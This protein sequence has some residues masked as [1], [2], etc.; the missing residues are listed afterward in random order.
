VNCAKIAEKVSG[1]GLQFSFCVK[2]AECAVI[3]ERIEKRVCENSPNS[4]KT[5][6]NILDFNFLFA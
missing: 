4:D 1:A 3:D 5:S 6:G 2:S